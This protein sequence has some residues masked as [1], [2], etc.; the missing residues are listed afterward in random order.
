MKAI[1]RA[2]AALLGL[3]LA[4]SASFGYVWVSP[5][6][7]QPYPQAPNFYNTGGVYYYDAWGR[8]MGPYYFIQ[9]PCPPFGGILPGKTGDAI[10]SGNLPHTLL[11]SKEGLAIGNVP[12]IG[13][14]HE[15][16]SGQ[17]GP[18]AGAGLPEMGARRSRT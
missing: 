5:V 18:H 8:V 4:G 6:F 16:G 13:Q 1:L 10:M 7:K 3:L 9:P 11:L 14:K 12:M 17:E 2:G 15:K